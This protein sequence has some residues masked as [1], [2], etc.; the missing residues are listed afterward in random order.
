MSVKNNPGEK[1]EGNGLGLDAPPVG[2]TAG[3][4]TPEVNPTGQ[5]NA[6]E[7]KDKPNPKIGLERYL[8]KYPQNSGIT[9][10]L[11]LKHKADV[12]TIPEWEAVVK[13]LLNKK[14]Q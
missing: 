6:G 12:K 13:E 7:K 8:Q 2:E 4:G 14:V 5:G 10:L 3:T 11:R 1:P 9:A